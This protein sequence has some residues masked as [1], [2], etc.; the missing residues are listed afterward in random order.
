MDSGKLQLL[1]QFIDFWNNCPIP[2]GRKEQ[3]GYIAG[4]LL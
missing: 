2:V 3:K 1:K 4:K